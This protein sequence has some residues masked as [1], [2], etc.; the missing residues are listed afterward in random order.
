[1]IKK[2]LNR[3]D[4]S[5]KIKN[6]KIVSIDLK[7][8]G[9][10][11]ALRKYA[12]RPHI[13]VRDR[14]TGKTFT[15]APLI[16]SYQEDLEKVVQ[17]ILE[18]GNNEWTGIKDE[19]EQLTKSSVPTWDEIIILCNKDWPLRVKDSPRKTWDCELNNLLKDDVPRDFE[20]LEN[21]V[22]QKWIT[23]NNPTQIGKKAVEHR[24]DT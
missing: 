13:F 8:N 10:R 23:G 18:T 4:L 5:K 1:M 15:C 14:K 22:R 2:N 21:W 20:S 6:S 16:H 3:K 12:N 24:L 11:W 9:C 17:A 7:K 19:S